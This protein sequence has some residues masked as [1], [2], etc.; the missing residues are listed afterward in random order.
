MATKLSV[1]IITLNEEL[2]IARC[3]DAA[4]EVADEIVVV[5]SYSTDATKEICLKYNVAYFEHIFE[6][7]IQQKNYAASMSKYDFVLSLDADE[8]LSE[9]L[10][11]SIQVIKKDPLFGAYS[12]NRMSHY[13]DRFIKNGHWFPD[14]KIRLF[15][16]GVG[17]WAGRNPHDVFTLLNGGRA[18]M[19]KGV[20]YHY[21]FNSVADHIKQANNFSEI[22][23]KQ[24][25]DQSIFFLMIKAIFSPFWGF[26]YGYIGRLGFLDGWYGLIIAIIAANETFLKYAKAVVK[27]LS[28][29]LPFYDVIHISS[30]KTW[31]GGEQ[32]VANLLLGQRQNGLSVFMITVKNSSLM[33]FCESNNI[34]YSTI[35][36]TNGFNFF[37]AFKIK[38]LSRRLQAKTLHMHCSPSHTL[39]I[40]SKLFGN[41]ANLVLSRRVIFPV[42]SN[43]LSYQKFNYNGISKIICV[44]ASTRDVISKTVKNKAKL[45]VIYDGI[46]IDKFN[47]E[48]NLRLKK[49]LGLEG[50]KIISN[51]SAIAAE[52]DYH[53]FVDVAEVIINKMPN[54]HF[55]IVGSGKEYKTIHSYIAEKNL[56][57]NISMLG[58]RNDIPN[59]LSIID[60][61]L[62]TSVMEGLG[63]TILDAFASKVPVVAT[64][65]GG[66]PEIVMHETTG[67]LSKPKDVKGLSS[68]VMRLLEDDTLVQS[69][70]N[71]AY[72]IVTTQFSANNMVL[73]TN[74]VYKEIESDRSL[75][76]ELTT[77]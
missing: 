34:P 56:Q 18:P 4:L 65:V 8:V 67:L 64:D 9:Q 41:P 51:I 46:D 16:K 5:D 68:N 48:A 35:S 23:S 21:T 28:K 24:L 42:R 32:Q 3:L 77:A 15:K 61:F 29:D 38:L 13:V 71:K 63:S 55:I 26:F 50:K 72:D 6:G 52:K 57:S 22:G 62:M 7:Y 49:K 12:I 1:V 66:I 76:N 27:I 53:T 75:S 37:S 19:L 70:T 30:M 39:A 10:I 73:E 2:N 54:T 40:F 60:V 33:N 58:F 74:A 45:K 17:H 44:S 36:F 25:D 20:L 31:R 43:F 69:I 47:G 14:K 11:N 59:L